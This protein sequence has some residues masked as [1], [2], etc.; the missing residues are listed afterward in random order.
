[1]AVAI[2]PNPQLAAI[3]SSAVYSIWFIFAGGQ[4]ACSQLWVS[5]DSFCLFPVCVKSIGVLYT[6]STAEQWVRQGVPA[7]RTAAHLCGIAC[8]S[9]ALE[10][11]CYASLCTFLCYFRFL[12]SLFRYAGVVELV[13]AGRRTKW[14]HSTCRCCG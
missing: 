6:P 8:H 13:S 2:S 5:G 7:S 1:M 3:M 9:V 4:Q 14:S 10:G 11:P 12:Y